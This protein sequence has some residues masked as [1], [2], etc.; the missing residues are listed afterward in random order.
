MK[1]T[2]VPVEYD[3]LQYNKNVQQYTQITNINNKNNN[4]NQY[5]QVQ[6]Y[7]GIIVNIN[8]YVSR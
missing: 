6:L 5:V 7:T 4:S 1:D 2:L 3:K 8:R